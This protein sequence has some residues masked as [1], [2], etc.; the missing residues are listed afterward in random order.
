MEGFGFVPRQPEGALRWT[1]A[2]EDS[3]SGFEPTAP[4]AIF[5]WKQA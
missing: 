5:R 2:L 4:E 1:L 3:W